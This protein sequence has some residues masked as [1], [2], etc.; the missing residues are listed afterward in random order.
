MILPRNLVGIRFGRLTVVK[1]LGRDKRDNS[2][3]LCKCDCGGTTE[4]SR[5]NLTCGHVKSCGCLEIENRKTVNIT[6]GG[7]K[8]KLYKVWHSMLC[9]CELK[10]DRA[11]KWY[12]ARGI[13]VCAEWHDFAKFRSWSLENGYCMG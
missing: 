8:T 3:W 13:E 2:R 12:G 11:F 4:V 1:F 9:R 10:N 6:H 5:N 7:S